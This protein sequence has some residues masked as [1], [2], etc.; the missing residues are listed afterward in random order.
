MQEKCSS[1]MVSLVRSG[2]G[3]VAGAFCLATSA[4]CSKEKIVSM[5]RE[6]Q[7]HFSVSKGPEERALEEN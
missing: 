2:S 7:V 4:P 5:Q 6:R 1:G 3:S